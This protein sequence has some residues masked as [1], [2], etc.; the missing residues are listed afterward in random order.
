MLDQVEGIEDRGLR[1]RPS[2]QFAIRAARDGT[3]LPRG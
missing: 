3:P 1:S 2:A